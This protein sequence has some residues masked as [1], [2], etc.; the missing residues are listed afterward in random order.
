MPPRISLKSSRLPPLGSPKDRRLEIEHDPL[1]WF[2]YS[3]SIRSPPCHRNNTPTFPYKSSHS[4][5][6]PYFFPTIH[7]SPI[8][9]RLS[10]APILHVFVA[11]SSPLLPEQ[12]FHHKK[13]GA[14]TLLFS[15]IFYVLL[16]FLWQLQE[17]QFLEDL[18]APGLPWPPGPRQSSSSG[19]L[20][21][22][23]VNSCQ[24]VE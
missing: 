13:K 20:G 11:N 6:F 14:F 19:P 9:S 7:T 15:F 8:F 21:P 2:M 12:R 5:H 24:E 23:C 1:T 3:Q 22:S 18:P 4:S 10:I 16:L 17:C